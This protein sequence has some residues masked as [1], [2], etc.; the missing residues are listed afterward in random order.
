[1]LYNYFNYK[2]IYD[3]INVECLIAQ[4]P[5]FCSVAGWSEI[6]EIK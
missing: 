5:A 2:Y 3:S 4:L 1:M 6:Q